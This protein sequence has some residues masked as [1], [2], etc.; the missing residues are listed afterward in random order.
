[1]ISFCFQTFDFAK[2]RSWK[3][4]AYKIKNEKV[5]EPKRHKTAHFGFRISNGMVLV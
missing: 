2:N 5:G 1:M 4:M 3:F